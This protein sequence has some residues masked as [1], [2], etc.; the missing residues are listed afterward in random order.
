[1]DGT[2][3]SLP[4]RTARWLG[5]GALC[6]YICAKA[7]LL[8]LFCAPQ[9]AA[10]QPAHPSEYDVKAVYL[11]NFAKF[12]QWP[13]AAASLDSFPIC[14]MGENPF[15]G[16]LQSLVAGEQLNGQKVLVRHVSTVHEAEQ[17]R[18][19]FIGASESYRYK[20]VIGSLASTPVL[21]VSDVPDFSADG[22]MIQLL[23]QGDRV[24][25]EV[26]L[27]AAQKA[28]LSLSS[29]LLKVATRVLNAKAGGD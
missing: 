27:A 26:N 18:V 14:I 13:S 21:T 17:C 23:L 29:Q 28:H 12:T 3:P 10:A 8:L 16:T 24:K 5:L 15:R 6:C 11:F 4:R 25:F 1:M 20:L 22:G 2:V 19:L 9:V 7:G